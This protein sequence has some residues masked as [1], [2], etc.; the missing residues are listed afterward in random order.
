MSKSSQ[1][2]GA[3]GERELATLLN[4]Y[5]FNVHRGG[6]FSFGNAPDLVGLPGIHIEVKRVEKLNLTAAVQQAEWDAE[7]FGDG[8]P[9]V[10]HRRNRGEWLVTMP[11]VGWI[12]LYKERK[13]E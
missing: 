6:S 13:E 1:R 2:K 11:L 8:S 12:E 7:K 9:T 4:G 5:G 10:F 3:E